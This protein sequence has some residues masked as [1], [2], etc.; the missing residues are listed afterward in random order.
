MVWLKNKIIQEY[1]LLYM[2][3]ESLN[4]MTKTSLTLSGDFF[5]IFF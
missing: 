4:K 5:N 3:L 1:V 2:Y